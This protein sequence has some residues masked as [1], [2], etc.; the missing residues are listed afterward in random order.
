M[1]NIPVQMKSFLK[2]S[3]AA[4][5][6]H[7]PLPTIYTWCLLGRIDCVKVNGTC[8]RVYTKS[9]SEFLGARESGGRRAEDGNS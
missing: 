4:A 3:E 6:F 9:L 5:R 1:E 7:V 2:P 8:L